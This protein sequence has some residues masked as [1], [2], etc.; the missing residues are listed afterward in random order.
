[1]LLFGRIIDIVALAALILS[2]VL[3]VAGGSMKRGGLST[4]ARGLFV[5]ATLSVVAAVVDLGTLLVTHRFDS[6]YVY[7]HSARAMAPLY[8]FPSMW[9]GQEGSFLLWAF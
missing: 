8:W 3:Y 1:M 5:L 7:N 4:A 9:A 2:T 6:D